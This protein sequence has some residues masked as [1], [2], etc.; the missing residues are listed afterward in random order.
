MI[1]GHEHLISEKRQPPAHLIERC[2]RSLA[3]TLADNVGELLDELRVAVLAREDQGS[4]ADGVEFVGAPALFESHRAALVY[5]GA[6]GQGVDEFRVVDGHQFKLV[7]GAHRLEQLVPEILGIGHPDHRFVDARRELVQGQRA[8]TV[9][10]GR[11][12]QHRVEGCEEA[13]GS[14]RATGRGPYGDLRRPV[15]HRL[16]ELGQR[17]DGPPPCGKRYRR[18]PSRFGRS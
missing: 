18:T 5:P 10:D 1:L 4:G 12:R 11:V 2:E 8:A 7:V 16:P 9:I 15:V 14:A 6:A 17:L 13:P 3:R